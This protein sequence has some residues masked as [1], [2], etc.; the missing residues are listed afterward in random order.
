MTICT[1]Y[2]NRVPSEMHGKIH[3]LKC[4]GNRY[5]TIIEFVKKP[6]PRY[7]LSVSILTITVI[8]GVYYMTKIITSKLK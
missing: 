4:V 8:G 1:V 5:P 3:F 2:Y 6:I 7:I